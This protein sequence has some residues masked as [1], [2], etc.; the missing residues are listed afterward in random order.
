MTNGAI[1]NRLSLIVLLNL[2]NIILFSNKFY[3][4]KLFKG[5]IKY[6]CIYIF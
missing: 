6:I 4:K 5:K 3:M 1:D 2:L